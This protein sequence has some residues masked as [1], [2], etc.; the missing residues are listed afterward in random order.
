MN[1]LFLFLLLSGSSGRGAQVM[2][3]IL[4]ALPVVPGH[5]LVL[6][7]LAAK[8]QEQADKEKEKAKE[9]ADKEI[10]V[11]VVTHDEIANAEA[12]KAKFPKLYLVFEKLPLDVQNSIFP[13]NPTGGGRSAGSR[14]P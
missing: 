13:A 9:Q 6:A 12:L 3:Q 8:R 4:P 14:K 7:A 10:L 11:D 5:R 1:P 2:Q